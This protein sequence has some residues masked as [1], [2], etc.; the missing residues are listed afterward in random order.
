MDGNSQEEIMSV[1]LDEPYVA[2]TPLANEV[3][4]QASA[5]PSTGADNVVEAM[6][7]K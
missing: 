2:Q 3:V 1:S 7:E 6:S 4:L 5:M